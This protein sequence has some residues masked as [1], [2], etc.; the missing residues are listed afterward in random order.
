MKEKDPEDNQ[1]NINNIIDVNPKTILT[2]N[3]DS[4]KVY[5]QNNNDNNL[6]S[7]SRNSDSELISKDI[8]T[9]TNQQT[10]TLLKNIKTTDQI[11]EVHD[12][13]DNKKID[14]KLEQIF[15]RLTKDKILKCNILINS[16]SYILYSSS[17]TFLLSAKVEFSFFNKNFLI[18][19]TRDFQNSS[20]V[21][22][23]HSYSNKSEFILYDNGE[24][25]RRYL[26]QINFIKDKRY[27]RFLVYLPN[28]DYFNN[29]KF[30][31]DKNHNDKLSLINDNSINILESDKP[32]YDFQLGKFVDS[33][34][35]RVKEK[36][37]WNF[38]ISKE[39]SKVVE[40]GKVNNSNY[41]LDISYP[42]SPLEAFAI[43]LAIFAK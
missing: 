26:L 14:L 9:Q 39:N 30:N 3:K 8:K 27:Q 12:N 37:K 43:A 20:I 42:L 33:Y 16:D 24:D 35:S 32:K 7:N 10:E 19:S 4:V 36:S 40:C 22:K 5:L 2:P 21:G 17:M 31:L 29:K 38:K 13:L 34:S 11:L 1:N 18:Y 15:A 23:L 25:K 28:D 6:H 41:T